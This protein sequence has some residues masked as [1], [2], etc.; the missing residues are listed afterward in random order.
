M[1]KKIITLI[2]VFCI[3][4][5]LSA[6][7]IDETRQLGQDVT[8][9]TSSSGEQVSSWYPKMKHS[10]YTYFFLKGLKGSADGDGDKSVTAEEI[11]SY[12][13]EEVSFMARK[14]NHREQT[15]GLETMDKK[16]VLV[17]Y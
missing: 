15:P 4:G 17:R 11:Q 9:F 1:I 14:L 13:N 8:V 16:R 5:I 3:G 10:L 2:A 7:S 6:Q 12:V